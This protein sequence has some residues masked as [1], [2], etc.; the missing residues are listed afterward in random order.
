MLAF[1]IVPEHFEHSK[2]EKFQHTSTLIVLVDVEQSTIIL[3]SQYHAVK[4]ESEL[5]TDIQFSMCQTIWNVT[6]L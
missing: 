6:L 4:P 2:L 1:S 5:C 3:S